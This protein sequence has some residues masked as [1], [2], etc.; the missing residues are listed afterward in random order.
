[1]TIYELIQKYG[2]NKGESAMWNSIKTIS[3][4]LEHNLSHEDHDKLL[5]H[6]YCI[7]NDGHYDEYFADHDVKH[8]YYVDKHGERHSAPYLT[9]E[10][11]KSYYL[12]H[13]S[14]I[15]SQYNM[16]DFYVT[17]QMIYSDNINLINQW[18]N[19]ISKEE[20][21]DKIID[22]SINW[23]NDEDNPFG[24]HKIWGYFNK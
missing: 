9:K 7:M 11:I 2:H 16:W 12:K 6:I 4:E 8:M 15:P 19:N 13:R 14:K 20:L 18:F 3:D 17:V 22:M 21:N 23:L 24:D 10:E 5:K 1:M